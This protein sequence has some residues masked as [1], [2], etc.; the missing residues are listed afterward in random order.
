MSACSIKYAQ[1]VNLSL[2]QAVLG[3]QDVCMESHLNIPV[4][5]FCKSTL[6]KD[7]DQNRSLE[8]T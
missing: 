6:P 3:P 8:H 1:Y 5:N 4:P 2:V 7:K